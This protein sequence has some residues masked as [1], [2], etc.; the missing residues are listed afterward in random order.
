MNQLSIL[1]RSSKEKK[2]NSNKLREALYS[3]SEIS[4]EETKSINKD[5]FIK[6]LILVFIYFSVI[7]YC[8]ELK[9]LEKTLQCPQYHL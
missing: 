4:Q 9:H 2:F 7:I 3:D 1:I 6:G 5:L 8:N